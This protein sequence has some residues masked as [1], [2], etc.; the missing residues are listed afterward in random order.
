MNDYEQIHM[1]E[2]ECR[3]VFTL[4]TWTEDKKNTVREYLKQGCWV[5]LGSS[6]LGHT[7]AR[8]VEYDG[9]EWMKKEFGKRLTIAKRSGWG[10]NYC[11]LNG[12]N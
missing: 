9:L 8:M 6:C 4:N 5:H 3:S 10:D 1:D 11:R 2:D 12:T 7:L